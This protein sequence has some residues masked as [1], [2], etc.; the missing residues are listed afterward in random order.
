MT[1]FLQLPH[2]AFRVG[3]EGEFTG[4]FLG[5]AADPFRMIWLLWFYESICISIQTEPPPSILVQ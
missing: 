2:K 5:S 4:I 1:H 3:H